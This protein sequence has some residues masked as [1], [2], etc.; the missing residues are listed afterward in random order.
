MSRR[1]FTAFCAVLADL[2]APWTGSLTVHNQSGGHVGSLKSDVS[3]SMP[4]P[5]LSNRRP[6]L[7]AGPLVR[8]VCSYVQ[9]AVGRQVIVQGVRRARFGFTFRPSASLGRVWAVAEYPPIL[10]G[11]QSSE[12]QFFYTVRL[13]WKHKR[14]ASPTHSE[15]HNPT[16]HC[17]QPD[18]LVSPTRFYDT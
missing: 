7:G 3:P 6:M 4:G 16:R 17:T 13:R 18:L 1:R 11:S 10:H 2:V 12:H 8:C 9:V 15:R 14:Q 5:C